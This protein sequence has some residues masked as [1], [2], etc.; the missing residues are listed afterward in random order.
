ML[1]GDKLLAEVM[2]YR[3]TTETAAMTLSSGLQYGR[4][5]GDKGYQMATMAVRLNWRRED[6]EED[7]K[8]QR[9]S[10]VNGIMH[11]KRNNNKLPQ[12]EQTGYNGMPYSIMP[13]SLITL[14]RLKGE[15]TDDK[16]KKAA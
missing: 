12:K 15:V 14:H 2:N 4:A 5:S 11:P 6:D 8:K 7:K 10:R 16:T 9:K 3:R 1:A 13:C